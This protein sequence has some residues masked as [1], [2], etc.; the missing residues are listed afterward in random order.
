MDDED[1]KQIDDDLWS[2]NQSLRQQSVLIALRNEEEHQD[3]L[4]V[5]YPQIKLDA[6][7]TNFG[8]V[9]G[10]TSITSLADQLTCHSLAEEH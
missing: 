7:A 4:L 2:L 6:T 5:L 9:S 8:G 1:L 3:K 10:Q